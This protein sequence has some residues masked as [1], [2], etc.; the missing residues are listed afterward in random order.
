MDEKSTA[1]PS[2]V[3]FTMCWES[4]ATRVEMS[5]W[6]DAKRKEK[7][8]RTSPVVGQRK[9]EVARFVLVVD[10]ALDSGVVLDQVNETSRLDLVHSTS[11]IKKRTRARQDV[12]RTY[13]ARLEIPDIRKLPNSREIIDSKRTREPRSTRQARHIRRELQD[14]SCPLSH[15]RVIP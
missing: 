5:F 2:F 13:E 14:A 1:S 4:A 9:I 11:R 10:L 12:T 7:R 15:T 3:A 8:G 6:D